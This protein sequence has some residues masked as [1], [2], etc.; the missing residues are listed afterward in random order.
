MCK[1]SGKHN[2]LQDSVQVRNLCGMCETKREYLVRDYGE[3]G[4]VMK[5]RRWS[6][7]KYAVYRGAERERERGAATG[8]LEAGFK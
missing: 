6:C 2:V 7:H 4:F 1:G 3:F 8:I 5:P